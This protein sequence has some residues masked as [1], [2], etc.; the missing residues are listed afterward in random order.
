MELTKR[1]VV[2]LKT[3][4]GVARNTGEDDAKEMVKLAFIYADEFIRQTEKKETKEEDL[5]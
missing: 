5:L 3:L 2:A 4:E 1:E